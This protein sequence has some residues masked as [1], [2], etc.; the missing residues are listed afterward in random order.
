M[1]SE[2]GSRG[3][4]LSPLDRRYKP[5][6]LVTH[7]IRLLT[8]VG[9]RCDDVS[10]IAI[11]RDLGVAR[12]V[13]MTSENERFAVRAIEQLSSLMKV[14]DLRTITARPDL[15]RARGVR[16]RS[17]ESRCLPTDREKTND[18][19][20]AEKRT[21]QE[22]VEVNGEDKASSDTQKS[23]DDGTQ[24]VEQGREE[25]CASDDSG[26]ARS[27]PEATVSDPDL[28]SAVVN[29]DPAISPA[30]V[31]SEPAISTSAAQETHSGSDA[32][33][34]PQPQDDDGGH[35]E[36]TTTQ[37]GPPSKDSNSDQLGQRPGGTQGQSSQ[38]RKEGGNEEEEDD[39]DEEE[40]EEEEVPG[41][42]LVDAKTSTPMV[43]PCHCPDT[44]FY[45]EAQYVGVETRHAEF[46]SAGFLK[47]VATCVGSSTQGAA[48][49]MW[50]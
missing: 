48:L 24:D 22:P 28:S 5:E 34:T 12:V 14:L 30:A 2:Q 15:G 7:I 10:K 46:K 3:F 9:L 38:E 44:V 41:P 21:E 32:R 37:S 47:W 18:E 50:A 42:K 45:L 26:Q 1:T 13:L 6:E 11:H 39:D 8:S 17:S 20:A 25:T 29:S 19:Q 40:E 27:L 31:T 33:C 43:S 16:D 36:G 23:S 35:K 49:S 4:Y